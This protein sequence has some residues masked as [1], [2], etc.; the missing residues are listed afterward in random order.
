[1]MLLERWVVGAMLGFA[2][3]AT[4]GVPGQSPTGKA[5]QKQP[6][7]PTPELP[8]WDSA[9][10]PPPIRPPSPE[11]S[12]EPDPDQAMPPEDQPDAGQPGPADSTKKPD[13]T[14]PA[15]P[16]DSAKQPDATEPAPSV[17]PAHQ[18]AAQPAPPT[19]QVR[20][21]PVPM[22]PL[23]SDPAQRQME[24]DTDQ[25]LELSEDLKAEV[26]RAGSNTLS[27]A[28]LRKADEIQRLVKSLKEQMK[29]RGQI[30][31]SKP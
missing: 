17:G 3:T 25:L 11:D 31:V 5:Q 15:P 30:A 10:P 28:A 12:E 1:M 4:A 27:L 2:L 6:A 19:V 22:L 16:A 21:K 29:E 24:E 14:Q 13:A 26:N 7:K 23:S 9:Q 20:H 8:P 18:E